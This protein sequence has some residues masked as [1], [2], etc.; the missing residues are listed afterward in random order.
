MPEDQDITVHDLI[1]GDA[2]FPSNDLRDF[3]IVR[4]DGTP[5]YLLASAVDDVEMKMTHVIRGEDLLPSTPRQLEIIHALG[6]DPPAYAHLPLIVGPN[7][8]PLSKRHGSV[9]VEWFREEGYLPEALV[10]YL[11]LL[12]WSYD[13]STTFF[14]RQELIEKFDLSRVSHNPAAFDREK[15]L[16][17]NGHYIRESPDARI[18]ELLV[19]ALKEAGQEPDPALVARAVP[20]VKER[21][22]TIREGVEYLR[23]LFEEDVKPDDKAAKFLGPERSE[24]L[25]EVAS[26]LEGLD[27]W[28]H[29][30]IERVLRTLQEE[31]ELSSKQA[32][33]PV[34][35]AI[36]GRVVTP[37]LFESVELLGRHRA[38]ERIRR[39]AG[40]LPGGT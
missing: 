37:P 21:M 8:Q 38:L 33:M 7:Q 40:A 27:E 28:R 36:T 24:Y 18:T 2:H 25:K 39:A 35:A 5:T 1:R 9:A 31:N 32:F 11:T 14:S 15:L 12:G 16:W 4:S 20:A 19:E 23:F 10:N 3:V 17:M 6:S 22:H 13:A 34:R 29:D 26:R 30:E